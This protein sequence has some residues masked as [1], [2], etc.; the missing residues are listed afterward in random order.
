MNFATKI[1]P[2]SSRVASHAEAPAEFVPG[3]PIAI[4]GVP[5]DNVTTEGAIRL[6]E[7]MIHSGNS[8][9]L[10]TAN[11]D[12]LVQ[13]QFDIELRRIFFDADLVLCDG[14]PLL[15]ASRLL[16][17]PLPE[18]VAGAD[19]V[20]LLIR[21]AEK[22]QYRVFFLGA[23][24]QSAAKAVEK[25]A[26]EFPDLNIAGSYSPPFNKLLEMDH[27]EIRRRILEG[28]PHL[29]F[30]SFGCPKQEKWIAMHYRSLGVPVAVG[31]G[32]TIDFLAGQVSRAPVWMR[33][34]GVEWI[35]RMAQ[36]PRRLAGRYLKD[37]RV[38]GLSILRQWW[39]LGRR[40]SRAQRGPCA[41]PATNEHVRVL[42]LPHRFDMAA[43]CA[44]E[45]V[46]R[47]ISADQK[48]CLLDLSDVTFIDSTGVGFL[49]HLQKHLRATGL[50]LILLSPRPSTLKTLKLMRLDPFFTIAADATTARQL[51]M[52]LEGEMSAAV[53]PPAPGA[54]SP[55]IWRGEIVA[56]NVEEVWRETNRLLTDPELRR[57]LLIDLSQVRFIDSSGLGLMVRVKKFAHRQKLKLFFIG[58]RPA[59][60]N[61]L[62]LARLEEFL[63]GP[64]E[65]GFSRKPAAL[66]GLTKTPANNSLSP[67]RAANKFP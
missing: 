67:S 35:Y 7:E 6:I 58:L 50:Q 8:H 38:F 26:R 11:V 61:V 54:S 13:A 23:T 43:V 17:N 42:K 37:L 57:A 36:E 14:T 10:V 3:P 25:L 51:I 21:E 34:G 1:E 16:G 47:G 53:M 2:P 33:H 4:L 32:A 19:L 46:R 62:H 9:Y 59:V 55:L 20:P 24:P 29:L 15:W 45:E 65:P 12:F 60:R 56:A 28:R 44:L 30:V 63:L 52:T 49:I 66:P 27:D 5:F 41:L 64:M 39:T 31:V 18:R 40:K 22:K 48:H